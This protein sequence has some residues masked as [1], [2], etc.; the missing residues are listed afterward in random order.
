MILLAAVLMCKVSNKDR[1]VT[2]AM[3]NDDVYLVSHA[4]YIAIQM[5]KNREIE[6]YI[7]TI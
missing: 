7:W 2:E 4:Q 5:I 3:T 1:F 6:S